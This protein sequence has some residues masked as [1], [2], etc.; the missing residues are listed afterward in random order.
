MYP[1][2]FNRINTREYNFKGTT[3]GDFFGLTTPKSDTETY[4]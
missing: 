2:V 4:Y 1:T 3:V